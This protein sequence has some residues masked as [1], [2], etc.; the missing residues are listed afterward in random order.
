MSNF[1]K[2]VDTGKKGAL[3]FSDASSK[4]GYSWRL[5]SDDQLIAVER[6]HFAQ[7]AFLTIP[8]RLALES[9]LF[10]NDPYSE[11]LSVAVDASL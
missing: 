3:I 2:P 10:F 11:R 7:A 8:E 6:R 5:T 1:V 4:Q 9:R